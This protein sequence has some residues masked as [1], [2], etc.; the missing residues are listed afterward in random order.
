MYRSESL[1]RVYGVIGVAAFLGMWSSVAV[2][3]FVADGTL[4]GFFRALVANPAVTMLTIEMACMALASSLFFYTEA[5]RLRMRGAWVILLL[6]LTVGF[7]V[8]F[9]LFLSRRERRLQPGG[10]ASR[11]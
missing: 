9:P 10:T 1:S 5:Q 7:G 11:P 4:I 6:A 2:F 8:V 3:F